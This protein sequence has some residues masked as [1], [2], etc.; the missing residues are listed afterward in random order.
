MAPCRSRTFSRTSRWRKGTASPVLRQEVLIPVL[1]LLPKAI[2]WALVQA[3]RESPLHEKALGRTARLAGTRDRRD[4]GLRIPATGSRA[5]HF[6]KE[7][8]GQF[9]IQRAEAFMNLPAADPV[10]QREV[11]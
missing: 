6:V 2:T 9:G 7:S 8:L 1:A 5:Q 4:P 10:A 11:R 3:L